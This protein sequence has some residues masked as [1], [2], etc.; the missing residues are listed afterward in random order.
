MPVARILALAMLLLASTVKADPGKVYRWVDQGG[1]VHYSD[2]AEPSAQEVRKNAPPTAI[3]PASENTDAVSDARAQECQHK[4]E[5]LITYRNAS[6]VTE[7]D[8]LGNTREYSPEE[9]QKLI[10]LN[11]KS[12]H[13]LCSPE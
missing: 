3:A 7:T 9:K 8:G 11:E 1:H 4:K 13:E 6:K 2:Q 10:E 12:V 5:Q